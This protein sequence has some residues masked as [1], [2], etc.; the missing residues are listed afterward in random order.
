MNTSTENPEQKIMKRHSALV[1]LVLASLVV[2]PLA[3]ARGSKQPVETVPLDLT[4]FETPPKS[5]VWSLGSTGAEGYVYHVGSVY[6]SKYKSDGRQIMVTRIAK[7]S[8][9]DGKLLAQDVIVG[10]IS[11]TAGQDTKGGTFTMEARRSMA[12]AI[13]EAEKKENGGKLVLNVWR[14]ETVV[15]KIV[16]GNPKIKLSKRPGPR[17]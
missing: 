15:E 16:Y 10:V 5:G 8:P 11:P 13:E 9:A 12:I 14:P 6:D 1:T 7:G 4:K 3:Q 2:C 17:P